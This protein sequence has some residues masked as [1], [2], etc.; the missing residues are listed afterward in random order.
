MRGALIWVGAALLLAGAELLGAEFFLLMLAVGALAAGFTA[1]V[2]GDAILLPA[3]VFLVVSIA[4]ITLV[5]PMLVRK[6]LAPGQ[7][8]L[9]I[10]RLIGA[11]A[12][13]LEE[14]TSG[15]GLAKVGGDTWTAR[16][17]DGIPPLPPGTEA[18]VREV[19]GATVYIE[20]A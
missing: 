16:I 8:K 7:P 2:T 10:D 4:M 1:A 12:L 18:R 15:H 11:H 9:G 3:I 6:M 5:R 13:V 20:R 17:P 19:R 14:V